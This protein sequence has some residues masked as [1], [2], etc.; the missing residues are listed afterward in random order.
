VLKV[1]ESNR[2]ATRKLPA[3]LLFVGRAPDLGVQQ[4]GF[5]PQTTAHSDL[6]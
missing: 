4:R 5:V 2:G 1:F 6:L 3:E